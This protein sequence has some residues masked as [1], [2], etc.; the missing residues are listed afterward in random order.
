[1]GECMIPGWGK[2][3]QLIDKKKPVPPY[4]LVADDLFIKK[5]KREIFVK[6]IS[7]LARDIPRYGPVIMSPGLSTNAN[8]FRMDDTGACLHLEHNRS[9][10]NLLASE[11]FD[12]YLHHPGYTDRVHNRYVCRH[13]PQSKYYKKRYRVSPS[14]G[15]GE[16]FNKEVPAVID[17]V[18]EYSRKDKVSW[19][20]YS[21]GAMAAYSYLAKH[22]EAPIQN[23][24]SICRAISPLGYNCI[25]I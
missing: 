6:R 4:L 1:M 2:K 17:F 13:C 25:N 3:R 16:L 8:I 18:R 10:A 24:I 14:F 19:V 11:G 22:P 15:Y 12:V 23:L 20:G 21:L 9:F 5:G 7:S